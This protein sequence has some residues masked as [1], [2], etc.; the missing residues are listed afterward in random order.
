MAGQV[1]DATMSELTHQLS[2]DC[3]CCVT[4][5]S[6][7]A[8][9]FPVVEFS[10]GQGSAAVAAS[11]SYLRLIYISSVKSTTACTPGS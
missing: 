1:H 8:S 7:T 10:P 6:V 11:L 5:E 9:S 2:V 3:L 4:C